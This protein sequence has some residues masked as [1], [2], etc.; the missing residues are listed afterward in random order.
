MSAETNRERKLGRLRQH[1]EEV[2]DLKAASQVLSW[3]QAI[4]MPPGGAMARGRQASR[5]A[6]LAHRKAIDPE[7]GR[8]L[9]E[10]RPLVADLPPDHVDAALV[11]VA[12][13]DFDR[14]LREP[15]DFVARLAEHG[16][17]AYQAW[18]AARPANDFDVM[19]PYLERGIELSREYASFFP[20]SDHIM[21]PFIGPDEGFTT[22]EIRALF[23]DLRQHLLPLVEAI[24]AEQPADDSCLRLTYS[25]DR[26]I[27]FATKVA[28][29][30]G[31]DMRRGRID[32][33]PHPFCTTF[34]RDDV[35]ITTRVKLN[36]LSEALFSTIHEVGHALY[37]MGIAPEL[38]GTPLGRGASAGVHESQS[39]LFENIVARSR[40]FWEHYYPQLQATFPGQLRRVSMDTFHRAIN[41]VQRS[42][43]RTDADEVTYN[44]HIMVRFEIEADL[45]EG[46]LAA[47]DLPQAWAER[48][49]ET[50]GMVAHNHTDGILQDVHWFCGTMAGHFQGYTIGNILAAQLF[51]AAVAERPE[52]MEGVGKGEFG[53]LRSW[54]GDRIHRHGRKFDGRE[55][56]RRTLGTDLSIAPYVRYLKTKYADLYS[57]K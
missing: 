9:E 57:L 52:I 14:Y 3:D 24:V 8:L 49:Q 17:A 53:A 16:S 15:E 18:A 35:R 51:E 42:V 29:D 50:V 43:I 2:S 4:Y 33:S 48:Y 7:I 6:A 47:K 40:P 26:Q 34:S 55:L 19:L 30:L 37:E 45:L 25:A 10:M 38:D 23:A 56:V 36:D 44:L 32:I 1:L 28:A 12:G 41:K 46:K 20:E 22:R 39:R 5:L 21:D 27:E 31:Y 54:L 11:R 13:R